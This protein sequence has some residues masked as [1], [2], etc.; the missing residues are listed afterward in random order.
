ME[1]CIWLKYQM[2][3]DE[4]EYLAIH[5]WAIWREKRKFLHGD[6]R[7][8][9]IEN[10]PWS[11]A[12]LSEFQKVRMMET[13]SCQS[14]RGSQEKTWKPPRSSTP[15]LNV[16]AVVNEDQNQYSV[17]EVVRDTQGRLFLAFGKQINQPISVVHGELLA[18]REDI[19]LFYEK[20]FQNVQVASGSFLAVQAVT[21]K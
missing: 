6:N 1:I 11:S 18:I 10:I 4:F 12:M 19:K 15:R 17:G 21:N 16:D 5:T 14:E 2:P 3:E 8:P 20:C 7:K 13:I 9:M